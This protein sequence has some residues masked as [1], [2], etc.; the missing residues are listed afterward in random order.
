[1]NTK[2]ET[3]GFVAIEF[4]KVLKNLWNSP[5]KAISPFDFEQ[6]VGLFKLEFA[7]R[8]QQDS[9]E[10]VIKLLEW[11]H[12]DTNK[13]IGSSQEPKLNNNNSRDREAASR[14]WR[15]YLERN[16]S[17]IIQLFSGQTRSTI[18][19]TSC[20]AESVTYMEF[21]ILTLPL[22]STSGP[23][24]LRECFEEFLREETVDK[25]TCGQCKNTGNAFKKTDIIKFPPV[26]VI[27]LSRFSQ[28]GRFVRKKQRFI[29]FEMKNLNLGY[30]AT[31]GFENKNHLYNLYAVS[32]HY[33][34]LR[35]GHYTAYCSSIDH[36]SWYKYDD[37]NVSS[38][39][40]ADVVTPAAYI[41][42]FSAVDGQT[43]FSPG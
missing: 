4:A 35:R 2:S 28:D 39:D 33:G 21:T 38:V 1:M 9:H 42:F 26:L 27:H 34:S 8:H 43:S 29:K 14:H 30:L 37:Q 6:V 20:L 5:C 13:V 32:N 23:A 22:P 3:G 15:N 12:C 11:L 16:Q 19:C 24:S 25:L 10:F 41:L 7:N 17:I 18:K 31:E 40:H 36:S